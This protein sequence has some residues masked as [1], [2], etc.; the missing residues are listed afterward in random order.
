MATKKALVIIADGT[1]EM[2]AVIAI[3]V[4][5]RANI[6][7]TVAGV[8]GTDLVTCSRNVLIKPDCALS[9]HTEMLFDV[10]VIPGGGQG[11]KRLAE[12]EEV[13]TMLSNHYLTGAVVAAICAGPT[14][15]QAHNIGKGRRITSYPSFK[16]QLEADYA[17]SEKNVVKDGNVITSR[18][19]GTAFEFA[20]EIVRTLRGNLMAKDLSEEMLLS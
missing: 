18:G 4:M 7:V 5:R 3:D 13:K 12:S 8:A 2:E 16:T 15:F 11:A 20:L 9:D 10:I 6:N 17:Y 19:P 14:A 1:E